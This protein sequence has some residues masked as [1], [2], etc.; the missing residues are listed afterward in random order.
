MK[1]SFLGLSFVYVLCC[2]LYTP[3]IHAEKLQTLRQSLETVKEKLGA[4]GN[5]LQSLKTATPRTSPETHSSPKLAHA[6]IIATG[7]KQDNAWQCGFYTMFHYE[8]MS[9]LIVPHLDQYSSIGAIKQEL[10]KQLK[11]KDFMAYQ[12]KGASNFFDDKDFDF[13]DREEGASDDFPLGHLLHKSTGPG[14]KIPKSAVSSIT[15]LQIDLGMYV[16]KIWTD[17]LPP[18]VIQLNTYQPLAGQQEKL[19]NFLQQKTNGAL[20]FICTGGI[21]GDAG[22]HLL[23]VLIKFGPEKQLGLI[24]MD[25]CEETGKEISGEAQKFVDEIQEAIND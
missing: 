9:T 21:G 25:S 22:H 4:L 3:V 1:V 18:H 7:L 13:L 16:L 15:D 5:Q 14:F 6:H 12:N 8:Q 10:Q 23:I 2:M 20:Y 11:Q 19:T 17:G 24:V